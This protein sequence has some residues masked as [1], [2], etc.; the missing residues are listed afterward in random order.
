MSRNLLLVLPVS[1]LFSAACFA[2]TTAFEGDVKGEDG[3]PVQKAVVKIDGQG[4]IAPWNGV[5]VVADST[6]AA[7]KGRD[8]LVVKW[9]EG[10][11]KNESTDGLMAQMR[12]LAAKPGETVRTFGDVDAVLASAAK[13]VESTYELPYLAHA[14]M[15]PM[16]AT[17]HVK[18]D[19]A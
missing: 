5:G 3:K 17:A 2:Q 15:E 7:M 4:P 18:N 13:K 19:G 8:A 6:W 9:D 1:L 10:A 12:E 11:A 16:N 14:T